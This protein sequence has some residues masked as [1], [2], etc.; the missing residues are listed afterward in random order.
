MFPNK[1]ATFEQEIQGP[2]GLNTDLVAEPVP[3]PRCA[4]GFVPWY[5]G[6]FKDSDLHMKKGSSGVHTWGQNQVCVCMLGGGEGEKGPH[7]CLVSGPPQRGPTKQNL[8]PL[9][10]EPLWHSSRCSTEQGTGTICLFPWP[11][12]PGGGGHSYVR[13]SRFSALVE[14]G[15]SIAA[16]VKSA[17][18][19]PCRQQGQP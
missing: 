3:M 8:R 7:K 14:T 5:P 16:G 15:H 1:S 2:T 19:N 6:I 10:L 13:P 12:N 4:G 17:L 18:G 9:V 11:G